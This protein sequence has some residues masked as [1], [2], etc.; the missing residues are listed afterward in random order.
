MS[1]I[2]ILAPKA[3]QL[4][5]FGTSV[6]GFLKKRPETQF[7]KTYN[8]SK[9]NFFIA[10]TIFTILCTRSLDSEGLDF[11]ILVCIVPLKGTKG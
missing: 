10:K 3:L 6:L 4:L 7:E 9:G 8:I 5:R 2:K 1:C 11:L